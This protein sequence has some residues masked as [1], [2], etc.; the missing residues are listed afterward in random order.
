MDDDL[1]K[2]N[3]KK[4]NNHLST[5]EEID[6]LLANY[7]YSS[8]DDESHEYECAADIYRHPSY[9]GGKFNF[10]RSWSGMC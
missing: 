3:D 8:D 10:Y 1:E 9:N 2:P 5:E 4:N 7:N 6:K